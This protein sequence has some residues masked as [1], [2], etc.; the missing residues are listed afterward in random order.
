M[1]E[2]TSTKDRYP[3]EGVD[4]LTFCRSEG[5]LVDYILYRRGRI[6]ENIWG[7]ISADDWQGERFW[8][9]LPPPPPER[10]ATKWLDRYP[11]ALHEDRPSVKDFYLCRQ[12]A[13]NNGCSWPE[14][15]IATSHVGVCHECNRERG[16]CAAS[17]WNW[18]AKNPHHGIEGGRET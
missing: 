13:L 2:W 11:V 1:T 12:C 4:V 7:R 16:L 15:H 8:R 10:E 5:Y 17:D 3:E 18:P 9:P 14:G 6:P